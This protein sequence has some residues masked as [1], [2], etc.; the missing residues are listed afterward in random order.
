MT[1]LKSKP[2]G[3]IGF[4]VFVIVWH[5]TVSL[6][7][8]SEVLLPFPHSVIISLF[9][10]FLEGKILSDI[11]LT[12]YRTA[13]SFFVAAVIGIP[14]GLVIGQ[15]DRL[16]QILQPFVDFFRSIP[17][18]ALFPL[19][20]LFFSL[21]DVSLFATVIFSVVFMMILSSMYGVHHANKTRIKLAKTLGATDIQIFTKIIFYEAL[22]EIMI[23]LR[24]A[25]SISLIVVIVS[26][27]FFGSTNGLGYR[28]YH[29]HILFQ[30]DIMYGIIIIIGIIGYGLNQLLI[31]LEKKL[32]HWPVK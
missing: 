3:L 22:P 2:A 6:N 32:I 24:H 14:V 8:F 5:I 16:Y 13:V 21:G 4:V 7:I 18:T 30:T 31:S 19:F 10:G 20:I 15:S 12:L 1:L 29:S 11:G 27:M 28:I 26:E 23:G 25:L 9:S 17:G